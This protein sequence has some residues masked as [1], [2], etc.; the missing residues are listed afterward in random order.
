MLH[1]VAPWRAKPSTMVLAVV[2]ALAAVALAPKVTGKMADFEVYWTAAARARAAE[3]LYR[4]EDGH[5]QF[6]YLPAF[7]VLTIPVALLPLGAAKALWFAVSVA[8]LAAFVS[9]S[10]ALLPR[11]ARPRWLI[12]AVVVVAMGKF[13]GHELVLGQVNLLFGTTVVLAVAALS[14]GQEAPAGALIALA[15][16]IKPYAVIFL[17]WLAARRRLASVAT[18][19]GGLLAALL[20]PALL[21]GFAGAVDLH[22]AWWRT[23]TDSTA[24]NLTNADNV[25]VAGMFSK[26][27]GVTSVARTATIATSLGLLAT[28]AF[29]FA[30]RR[31]V[32]RPDVLEASLLLMLIPL[33]SPQ[34]WDYV[35]LLATPAI[36]LLANVDKQLPTVMRFL[37]IAA[38]LVIGLSLYDVMGRATYASFM[39]LS[40]ITLCFLVLVA[41]L[42]TLRLRATA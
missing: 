31:R 4:V 28:A 1:R 25:S 9:L 18:V 12:A 2:L 29:V 7:A 6:K 27:L 42:T 15:I 36:A 8:L 40:I 3:P 16:V 41:A 19:I 35:F 37:T 5:Y 34:G 26:W 17:P 32:E 22:A 30:R 13:Y 21:Y 23:V 38:V 39:Q 20:L 10:I 11:L 33:L 14:R 24:P